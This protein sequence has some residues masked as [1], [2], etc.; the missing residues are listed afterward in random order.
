MDTNKNWVKWKDYDAYAE[1]EPIFILTTTVSNGSYTFPYNGIYL[2]IYGGNA[3]GLISSNY[4]EASVKLLGGR[5]T[6]TGLIAITA[7]AGSSF[8][9]NFN[10]GNYYGRAAL[11]YIGA[12]DTISTVSFYQF[13]SNV[14]TQTVDIDNQ[15]NYI[16][17]SLGTG[18]GATTT[19]SCSNE[20]FKVYSYSGCCCTTRGTGSATLT[21]KSGVAGGGETMIA[22]LVVS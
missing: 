8:T 1:F 3:S 22:K 21:Q 12:Y 6:G 13:G 18:Q 7:T 4:T 2:F 17:I 9:Y 11:Y 15:K 5:L 10:I 14:E 20:D 19:A 16:L